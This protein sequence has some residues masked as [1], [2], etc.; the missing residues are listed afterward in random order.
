[1][2]PPLLNKMDGEFL[3]NILAG[4]DGGLAVVGKHF[5]QI[6]V[7]EYP[8]GEVFA[9]LE[10][11]RRIDFPTRNVLLSAMTA[12]RTPFSPFLSQSTSRPNSFAAGDW[13]V[14]SSSR[15]SPPISLSL[16]TVSLLTV[17]PSSC[18]SS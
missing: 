14:T 5:H 12:I 10:C 9:G 15:A 6:L 18:F 16:C 4:G 13:K 11:K 1:M 17:I 2:S 7:D 8:Q 3:R